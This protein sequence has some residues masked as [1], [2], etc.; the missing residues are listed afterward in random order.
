MKINNTTSHSLIIVHNENETV[1]PANSSVRIEENVN[2]IQIKSVENDGNRTHFKLFKYTGKD[3]IKGTLISFLPGFY[4]EYVTTVSVD[5]LKQI[6]IM[7]YDFTINWLLICRIYL[8]KENTEESFQ[9]KDK[10]SKL[11]LTLFALLFSL[12]TCIL[13]G[14][15][16]LIC[17]T[18]L[19]T[20]FDWSLILA[21]VFS[22][23]LFLCFFFI[24][25]DLICCRNIMKNYSKI[26][27]KGKQV[28]ITKN[29]KR[30]LAYMEESYVR[31]NIRKI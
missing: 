7:Q 24:L 27:D 20:D 11:L 13:T 3:D 26:L 22:L 31:D 23:A 16:T 14:G 12:P 29:D 10:K 19:F 5:K 1:C 21:T 30:Y 4:N 9:F 6:S 25:R 28:V 2:K 15:I 17:L 8:T 18:G